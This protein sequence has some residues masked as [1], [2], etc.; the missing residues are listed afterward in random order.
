[1]V[2][3]SLLR[4]HRNENSWPKPSKNETLGQIRTW[5]LHENC[6]S[7]LTFIIYII[8]LLKLLFRRIS[9][10]LVV[11]NT[12]DIVIKDSHYRCVPNGIYRPSKGTLDWKQSWPPYWRVV[13][14]RSAHLAISKGATDGHFGLPW[15]FVLILSLMTAPPC[16]HGR[17]SQKG[18]FK[19]RF[20]PLHPSTLWSSH[21][22][23]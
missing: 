10:L 22:G 2:A 17:M 13:P 15:S 21:S 14:N 9:V 1:M 11:D 20:G 16:G 5:F 18:H 12:A 19:K 3:L 6:C 4:R 23:E 7:L 8:L